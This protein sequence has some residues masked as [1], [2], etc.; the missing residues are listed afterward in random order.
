M[1]AIKK[2]LFI[3]IV[4]CTASVRSVYAETIQIECWGAGASG[5][6]GWDGSSSF[7]GGGGGAYSKVNAFVVAPTGYTAVVGVGG[8]APNG[9]SSGNNGG[10]STFNSTSCVA[11]GGLHPVH[12]VAVGMGG[13]AALGIGD[14]KYSGGNGGSGGGGGGGSS[15]GTAAN[16][17]NG[18][19]STGGTAPVGGG[20]GGNGGTD[21][22]GTVGQAGNG[23][24]PGGGGGGSWSFNFSSAGSGANGKV[25]I[26]YLTAN[27]GPCTGGAITTDGA[28]T[29]HTFT[30]NGTFTVVTHL[31]LTVISSNPNSG[32]NVTVSPVDINSQSN[33]STQFTRT[34]NSGT[35]VTL[36]APATAGGNSFLKWQRGGVDY[37]TD[38][39]ITFTMDA[40]YTVTAVYGPEPTI[41]SITPNSGV[42]N[43]NIGITN[44]AGIGFVSGA[45][46]KLT[47]SGQSDIAATNVVFVN[48]TQLTCTLP[49]SDAA[50]GAWN[51]VVTNPDTL[52][53]SLVNGFT[54]TPVSSTFLNPAFTARATT[55]LTAS[56]PAVAGANYVAVLASDSGYSSIVSSVTQSENTKTFSGLSAGTAYYFEVKLSTETDDAFLVNRISTTTNNPPALAWTGEAN[57]TADGLNP[58][59]GDT[60]TSFT[61]R[62]KYTDADNDSP[63]SGYPKV[64]ITR[65]CSAPECGEISGSPF[66]MTFVS[67]A[68]NTGAVYTY[69][70]MLGATGEDYTYYFEARDVN[71]ADAAGAPTSAVDAPDV[72]LSA[73]ETLGEALD[74]I[75]LTW[76]TFAP[77]GNTWSGQTAASY[78]GG[79]SA[80]S[81][82]LPD[83]GLAMLQTTVSGPGTVKFYWKVSSDLNHDFLEFYI[84]NSAYEIEKSEAISGEVGWQ[85]KTFTI[86][87]AG[88]HTLEWQYRKDGSYSA[89]A[90]CGWLDKVEFV[91]GGGAGNNQQESFKTTLGDNL[92]S[93]KTGGS[94]KIKFNVPTAGTVSLKIYDLSGKLMRALFEGY[95]H[96][97]DMQKDW[98]GKD[99][100]G[101]YVVPSVYFL[102]YVYPGGKEVRKIGVKK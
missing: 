62:V 16:G 34:Y 54:V 9:S 6:R 86:L 97:G 14:V 50:I 8:V 22:D 74:N 2:L 84:T 42:N 87:T 18:S 1:S 58:E 79:S 82:V 47:K 66:A 25:V 81:G 12:D 38:Q 94:A 67:G 51:V 91:P 13:D 20:D 33:G 49:I 88:N 45:T 61:Y 101:R 5:G 24:A 44:L 43:A 29:I 69:S 92:F 39:S 95:S 71:S 55:S 65:N 102:H 85:Q 7:D 59:T 41:T 93:P 90:D 37:S 32:V 77:S 56:W 57:Y 17:N 19:G 4:L 73:G 75:E 70:K 48:S 36:T 35:S 63:A 68:Y 100:S 53:G 27:L 23:A 99:D 52:S 80:Q 60:A 40:D 15:A 21:F 96:P 98:D 26:T 28:Y 76:V 64:H 78:Y 3:S 11:K 46:V 83:N 89:G 31:A 72:V 30:S 10:D